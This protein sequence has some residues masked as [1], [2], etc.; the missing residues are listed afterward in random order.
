MSKTN[1][2]TDRMT[3][4]KKDWKANKITEYLNKYPK[5]LEAQPEVRILIEKAVDLE[6]DNFELRNNE[7]ESQLPEGAVVLTADQVKAWEAYQV[8]GKPEEISQK[9][10]DGET[11][12]VERDGLKRSQTLGEVAS[13]M[14]WNQKA[15]EEIVKDK[16][17]TF[18]VTEKDGKKSVLVKDQSGKET[19]LDEYA[20][21]TWP[22]FMPSLQA[23]DTQGGGSGN[24]GSGNSG[25]GGRSFPTGGN[26]GTQGGGNAIQ[27]RLQKQQEA[28]KNEK[29]FI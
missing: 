29:S 25:T 22:V 21:S 18:S 5:A 15:L 17:L 1:K 24:S 12:I 3:L 9:L 23:K 13:A 2:K 16:P 19:A 26:G 27:Q 20:K 11:A 28:Q 10:K 4:D 14:G 8:L 7:D 6:S